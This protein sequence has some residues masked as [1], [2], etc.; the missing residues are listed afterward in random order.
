MLIKDMKISS[1]G[2]QDRFIEYYERVIPED[3]PLD[4]EL[5]R[6]FEENYH[7]RMEDDFGVK[8]KRIGAPLATEEIGILNTNLGHHK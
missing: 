1:D 6:K 3:N 4:D 2:A 7:Q 8:A 5:H